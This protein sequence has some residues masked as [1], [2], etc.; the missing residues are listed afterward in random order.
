M[1]SG[2]RS[3]FRSLGWAA[4]PLAL[5]VASG[6]AVGPNYVEPAIETPA[7]DLGSDL[8]RNAHGR[9]VGRVSVRVDRGGDQHRALDQR[10]LARRVQAVHGGRIADSGTI[11]DPLIADRVVAW[12]EDRYA[13]RAAG[14]ADAALAAL[15]AALEEGSSSLPF[16]AVTPAFDRLRGDARFSEF[17]DRLGLPPAA[18]SAAAGHH[19]RTAPPSGRAAGG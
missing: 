13:R 16:A 4:I 5:L 18:P 1:V 19:G 8:R 15:E 17:L 7:H 10:A 14:D 12:L 11:R 3:S 2:L 6:C 9:V